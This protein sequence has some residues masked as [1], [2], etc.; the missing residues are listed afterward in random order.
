VEKVKNRLPKFSHKGDNLKGVIHENT[1]KNIFSNSE[2]F[3]G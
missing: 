2:N 3:S 1:I